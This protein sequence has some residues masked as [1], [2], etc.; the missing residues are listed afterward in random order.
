VT[1][2]P[3]DVPFLPEADASSFPG[4]V[5]FGPIADLPATDVAQLFQKL[6]GRDQ[7][8][9]VETLGKALVDRLEAGDG[10]CAAALTAQQAGEA[11]R[12]SQ[13]P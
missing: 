3:R 10:A 7:I 13:L 5:G 8:G 2:S 11:R 4:D 1:A 12:R 9:S 6:F